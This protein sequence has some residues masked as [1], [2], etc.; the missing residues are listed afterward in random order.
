MPDSGIPT[1]IGFKV[2]GNDGKAYF[3]TA[4]SLDEAGDICMTA[5]DEL[6]KTKPLGT[7]HAA[8]RKLANGLLAFNYRAET[9]AALL[10]E[11]VFDVSNAETFIRCAAGN[12]PD[13]EIKV[14]GA[15]TPEAKNA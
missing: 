4:A 15:E 6:D 13:Y 8:L 3:V 2:K 5:I 14:V 10:K 12:G 11:H 1:P 9:I 7:Q